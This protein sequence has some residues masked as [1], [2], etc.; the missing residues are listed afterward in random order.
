[1]I[2]Y[3]LKCPKC[4]SYDIKANDISFKD[5]VMK[6]GAVRCTKCG[7]DTQDPALPPI[8]LPGT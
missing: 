2:S 6:A 4:G 3:E 1:M 7:H 5:G 8:I